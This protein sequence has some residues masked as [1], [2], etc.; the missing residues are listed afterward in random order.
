MRSS[1]CRPGGTFTRR[2]AS[3]TGETVAL[4]ERKLFGGTAVNTG[5]MPTKGDG[6]ERLCDPHGP[7]RS[8]IRD[9]DRTRLGRFR[10]LMARKEK[11]RLDAAQASRKWL[12]GMKNCTVFAGHSRFEVRVS[13]HRRRTISGERIFV[14]VGGRARLPICPA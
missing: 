8:R 7:T 11:V 3:D 12:K 5:C 14:N 1:S 2:T 13:P 9:D 4:I 6:R 10:S